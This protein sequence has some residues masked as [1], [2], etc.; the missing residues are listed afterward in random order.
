[1]G[2][3]QLTV[4]PEGKGQNTKKLTPK[5][6]GDAVVKTLDTMPAVTE[7]VTPATRKAPAEGSLHW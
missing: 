6:W 1:M 2:N 4:G 7:F 3:S 5:V